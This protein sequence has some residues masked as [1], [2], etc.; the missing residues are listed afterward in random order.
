[1]AQADDTSG[2]RYVVRHVAV[3]DVPAT[4][5]APWTDCR[6][7]IAV[8]RT[9][10]HHNHWVERRSLYISDLTLPAHPWLTHI[11]ARW[12]IENRLHWICDATFREDDP[13]RKG[14]HAP[15]NWAL[16][17]CWIISVARRLGYRTVPLGM[18]ALANQLHRV[19]RILM[20]G[21]SSA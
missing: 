7:V 20:H 2:G 6:H 13:P 5:S 4:V 10:L 21:F 19:F 15:A 12:G 11:Q 3:F 18:Q 16:I 1:M 8:T 14:G 17:H 9:R